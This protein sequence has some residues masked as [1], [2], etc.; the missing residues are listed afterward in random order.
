MTVDRGELTSVDLVQALAVISAA[1]EHEVCSRCLAHERNL[2]EVGART[3]VRAT[4][5][6]HDDRIVA[7]PILFTYLLDLVDEDRQ[8]LV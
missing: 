1:Q 7:Q 3:P 2:G 5:H 4:G 8:V 6:P